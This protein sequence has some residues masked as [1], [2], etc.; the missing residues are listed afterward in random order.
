M[1]ESKGAKGA[2]HGKE[3]SELIHHIENVKQKREA[4]DKAKHAHDE[5]VWQ[6]LQRAWLD[7]GHTDKR[8]GILR[9]DKVQKGQK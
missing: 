2:K 4:L 7:D 6:A 5:H 8:E 1:A 9:V 3:A